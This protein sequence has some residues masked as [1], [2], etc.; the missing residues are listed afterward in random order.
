MNLLSFISYSYIMPNYPFQTKDEMPV[1]YWKVAKE[2]KKFK[3]VTFIWTQQK[4]IIKMAFQ[5]AYI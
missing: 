5:P 1:K 2:Y 4:T 3:C